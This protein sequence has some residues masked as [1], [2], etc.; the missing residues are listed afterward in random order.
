[1]DIGPDA[2]EADSDEDDDMQGAVGGWN[3]GI[4][5]QP[6]QHGHD[7]GE[8][9]RLVGQVFNPDNMPHHKKTPKQLA[10]EQESS[11]FLITHKSIYLCKTLVKL[12]IFLFM[13]ENLDIE[14]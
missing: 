9:Q 6:G 8:G 2:E 13:Y 11:L 10:G 1:M 5:G 12:R 4:W 7:W 14:K 3:Q